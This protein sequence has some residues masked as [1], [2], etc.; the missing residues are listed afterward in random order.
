[1]SKQDQVNVAETLRITEQ[2]D[3]GQ[4]LRD[5]YYRVLQRPE[6]RYIARQVCWILKVQGQPAFYLSLRDLNDLPDLIKSLSLPEDH[7]ND[8][9]NDLAVFV[10][11]SSLIPVETC[12]GVSA[13]VLAVDQ[14]FRFSL[15]AM[16][17][18]AYDHIVDKLKKKKGDLPKEEEDSRRNESKKKL[19]E[20]FHILAQSS[21][22][23]G[24]TYEGRALNYLAVRYAPVYEHYFLKCQY[25]PDAADDADPDRFY[26]LAS[27]TVT[28]SPLTRVS[29]GK[30]IVDVIISYQNP[31]NSVIQ[32]YFVRVDV[33]YMFPMIVNH[34]SPYIDR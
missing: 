31:K 2:S 14:L 9:Y 1:L 13:P 6:A 34:Y 15:D 10:G 20:I 3:P 23:F 27:V 4:S 8:Y 30:H 17:D 7:G 11:S 16:F 29:V 5:W 24:D 21:D 33:S 28:P 12:P 22:N 25:L 18:H 19:K 26:Y 32:K